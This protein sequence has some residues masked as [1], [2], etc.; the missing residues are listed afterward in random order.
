MAYTN[1]PNADDDADSG[2]DVVRNN[3]KF[4]P[5]SVSCIWMLVCGARGSGKATSMGACDASPFVEVVAMAVAVV[6][7]GGG[8]ENGRV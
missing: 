8:V 5:L 1:D 4:G 7:G 6:T 3:S 2:V